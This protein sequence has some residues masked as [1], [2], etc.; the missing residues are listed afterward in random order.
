MSTMHTKVPPWSPV[1]SSAKNHWQPLMLK[2]STASTTAADPQ[3]GRQR[4]A[5][6]RRSCCYTSPGSHEG[7]STA[8]THASNCRVSGASHGATHQ[9]QAPHPGH[10]YPHLGHQSHHHSVLA[11]P[12]PQ[13]CSGLENVCAAEAGTMA[14]SLETSTR[15]A[16]EHL[17]AEPGTERAGLPW[18]K[19]RG[20]E[21]LR[22]LHHWTHQKNSLIP[23]VFTDLANEDHFCLPQCLPQ[24]TELQTTAPL[25]FPQSQN[26]HTS[27]LS[28]CPNILSHV[29][30]LPY[31]TNPQEL[32]E[33]IAPSNV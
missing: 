6:P 26:R 21:L 3:R 22:T 7:A 2:T 14:C 5:P 1:A 19:E 16:T 30:T 12:G 9:T 20:E 23:Q 31:Q 10:M 32:E 8:A 33:E 4:C 27:P 17:Q 18:K 28:K 11:V 24:L 15:A 13:R 29:K 25:G